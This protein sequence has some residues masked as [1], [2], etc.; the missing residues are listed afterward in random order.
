MDNSITYWPVNVL[1]PKFPIQIQQ[2]INHSTNP[3]CFLHWHEQLEFYYV[4]QGG[5]YLLCGGQKQWIYPGDIAFV[6]W[7][8]LHK[9]LEFLDN[10][11]HYIIQM[12]LSLL[13][14]FPQDIFDEV[15]I[16]D[17]IVHARNFDRF[18]FQNTELTR[19]FQEIVAEDEKKSYGYELTIK[20]D[21]LKIFSIIFRKYYH[22]QQDVSLSGHSLQYVR[23]ILIYLSYHYSENDV[24]DTLSF[25][26]GISKNYLSR[27][28][29]SH[30][31]CTVVHYINQFRCYKAM[32]LI[33]EGVS[34]T[35]AALQVGYNDYNYF[36]RVF[37][38]II[39]FSP[40]HLTK[41]RI[42]DLAKT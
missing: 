15:Y 10:T 3:G 34:I 18:I 35:S 37:K 13:S 36:S 5:L 40:S 24:M 16:N 19:L 9:S 20:S 22:S 1:P 12:D 25:K 2:R 27:I 39:G 23:E 6:N 11:V 17:L 32:S 4:T 21:F 42:D 8:D 33:A 14:S 38:Q 26:I 29:R 28:F 7:C 41:K 30:T 31:G